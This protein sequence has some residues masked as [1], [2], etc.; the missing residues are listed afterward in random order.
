MTNGR[1]SV[2]A[3]TKP[4]CSSCEPTKATVPTG[5]VIFTQN[6]TRN[7]ISWNPA[8]R[9]PNP[10][11]V[12][13]SVHLALHKALDPCIN[14]TGDACSWTVEPSRNVVDGAAKGTTNPAS[15]PTLYVPRPSDIKVTSVPPQGKPEVSV[16]LRFYE[17][18]E[19]AVR[20]A[21]VD[22]ALRLF[23]KM[24]GL[25]DIDRFVVGFDQIRWAGGDDECASWDKEVD[26]LVQSGV[27]EVRLLRCDAKVVL[28]P[29]N[30]ERSSKH[31][32]KKPSL[33]TIGVS[34][35]SSHHISRL[36]SQLPS[37]DSAADCVRRPKIDQLNFDK[38]LPER[39]VKLAKEEGI[40]LQSHSD[41][42]G[43]QRSPRCVRDDELTSL[44]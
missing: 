20:C 21:Q 44:R 33:R 14:G 16:K 36:L 6:T 28:I 29:A 9:Q 17:S 19:G 27:W 3:D 35:F 15:Q 4:D 11:E 40:A 43:G 8:L 41:N 32:S 30:C 31:I 2:E 34:D 25:Q 22:E 42:R 24:T 5:A 39:L 23:E 10:N 1:L 13:H 37:K 12:L 7:P 26:F 38:E 18:Q